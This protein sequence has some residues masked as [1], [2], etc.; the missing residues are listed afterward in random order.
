M[1]TIASVEEQ[2]TIKEASE[3]SGGKK[4]NPSK[5]RESLKSIFYTLLG[6][7]LFIA[8]WSLV[9][10]YT[11]DELPGPVAT[12]TVLWELIRDPFYDYGPNDK[13]IGLQLMSSLGRVLSGF[14]IG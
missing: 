1:E 4:F 2:T 12:L 13:G 11:K 5:I 10:K 14:L 3:K 7:A 6:L 8:F 9:S